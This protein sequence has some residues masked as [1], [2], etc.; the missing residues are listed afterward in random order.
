MTTEETLYPVI[1]GTLPDVD[2]EATLPN[3]RTGGVSVVRVKARQ[4]RSFEYRALDAD[5]LGEE[6]F[7][8]VVDRTGELGPTGIRAL[9]RK[10]AAVV[11]ELHGCEGLAGDECRDPKAVGHYVTSTLD[12]EAVDVLW[13]VY[14]KATRV[15]EATFRVL[16]DHGAGDGEVPREPGGPSDAQRATT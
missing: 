8:D 6:F 5:L 16:R 1:S 12:A 2:F 14:G 15:S 4:L 13:L 10:L 3:R 11:K 7:E 9:R